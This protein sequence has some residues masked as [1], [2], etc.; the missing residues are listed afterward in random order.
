MQDCCCC[1]LPCGVCAF[2]GR[3]ACLEF[4]STRHL[5]A[6]GLLVESR[7]WSSGLLFALQCSGRL[8]CHTFCHCHTC[9]PG[10]PL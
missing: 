6:F 3:V 4:P 2:L 5:P 1:C 7:K 10:W 8:F 9:P